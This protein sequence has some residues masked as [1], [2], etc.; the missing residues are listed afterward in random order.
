[1]VTLSFTASC[2]RPEEVCKLGIC[3]ERTFALHS[4]NHT[5][6]SLP[7]TYRRCLYT[8]QDG[9]PWVKDHE[10]AV[11]TLT[12]DNPR[13]HCVSRNRMQTITGLKFHLRAL[14]SQETL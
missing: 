14:C 9:G 13:K 6:R 5:V 1:M 3:P 10:P 11:M 8:R 7:G 4:P 2:E 12:A